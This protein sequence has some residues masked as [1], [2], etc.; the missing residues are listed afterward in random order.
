M[1]YTYIWVE[2]RANLEELAKRLS[3][4]NPDIHWRETFGTH[5][6]FKVHLIYKQTFDA[7][8]KPNS[9]HEMYLLWM[10]IDPRSSAKNKCEEYEIN[11]EIPL[12]TYEQIRLDRTAILKR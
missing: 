6:K 4:S 1:T 11:R 3:P 5:S 2:G 10:P 12:M 8:G 9:C 7:D